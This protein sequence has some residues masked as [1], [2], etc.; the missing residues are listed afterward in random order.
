MSEK[1]NIISSL[2]LR[3]EYQFKDRTLIKEAL[4]HPSVLTKYNVSNQRLEFLGDRVLGLYVSE[5]LF[6]SFKQEPEGD[7]AKRFA[8]L[9]KRDT[10]SRVAENLQIGPVIE[11]SAGEIENGGQSNPSNLADALEAIIAALYIDGGPTVAYNFI[12][13]HWLALSAEHIKP[14][15]DAKTRLQEWSQKKNGRLP[16]YNVI[17]TS[18]PPHAPIFEVEVRVVGFESARGIGSSKQNAEQT[19]ALNMLDNLEYLN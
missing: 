11:M 19:A 8:S 4:R 6:Y 16:E 1:E 9:V 18:G 7:L 10:L 15:S 14:P 17:S 5:F 3:L 12:R 13:K 2:E